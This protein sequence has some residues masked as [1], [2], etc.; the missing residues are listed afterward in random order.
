MRTR[1]LVAVVTTTLLTA[2]A[3]AAVMALL[4]VAPF[5]TPE[6]AARAGG[7][8]PREIAGLW[9]RWP[10]ARS[11]GDKVRFWFFHPEGIG[12]Y[13]YGKIGLNTTNSFD[14]H[15]EGDALVLKFRK[16][17][18][19]RRTRFTLERGDEKHRSLVL[20]DDPKESHRVRYTFIPPPLEAATA[21]DLFEASA[22]ASLR[23]GGKKPGAVA[24]RLWIDQRRF[25]TGGI[26]F[27]LYQLK[28]AAID[29]RG[30]GWHHIGDYD[31][32]STEALTFRYAPSSCRRD[33]ELELRFTVRGEQARTLARHT[34]NSNGDATP[35]QK[36][37]LTLF[38]DPRNF[39]HRQTY[40]DAG[41]SFGSL[42]HLLR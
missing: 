16:T 4:R 33:A 35:E 17:G 8:H 24:G 3:A 30:V 29:G 39:W 5:G 40:R 11:D 1:T 2:A 19:L 18:E 7:K 42:H 32:W 22:P 10:D 9:T 38:E 41:P 23:D 21:P 13:R 20:L 28:E 37:S 14:W 36:A 26:G 6:G 15:V 27:S 25:A 34:P 31:D 12:L